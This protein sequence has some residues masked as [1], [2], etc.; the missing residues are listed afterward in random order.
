MLSAVEALQSWAAGGRGSGSLVATDLGWL[1][2]EDLRPGDRVVTFDH[3]MQLLKSVSVSVVPLP[4]AAPFFIAGAG[5][6]GFFR[7]KAKKKTA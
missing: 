5:A 1:P 7:R 3:G 6:L 2:V 4:A